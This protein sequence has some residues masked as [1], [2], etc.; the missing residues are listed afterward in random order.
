MY[1]HV[2]IRVPHTFSRCCGTQPTL[3]LI[4]TALKNSRWAKREKRLCWLLLLCGCFSCETTSKQ[5]SPPWTWLETKSSL[6][7]LSSSKPHQAGNC[8]I[9]WAQISRE[10]P[11]GVSILP[12]TQLFLSPPP[13]PR[14]AQWGP[15]QD[16]LS[17]E[18]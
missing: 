12:A 10:T 9:F 15:L 2:Q 7:N 16:S 3:R 13:P 4:S 5:G 8:V 18:A 17:E 6:A 14:A 11:V 1:F